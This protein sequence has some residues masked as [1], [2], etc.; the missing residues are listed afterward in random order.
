MIRKKVVKKRGSKTHGYGSKKK[1][2]GA[3]SRGGRGMAGVAK[4]MKVWLKK[5]DPGHLGKRGFKTLA[6]RKIISGTGRA[7]NLRDVEKLAN[8]NREIDLEKIG[9]GKVLATG[10]LK[11]PLT[12]KALAFSS[13]ARQK[14]EK[15]GGRAISNE[16]K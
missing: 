3:G 1:H 11:K 16:E 12:V 2:R 5:N 6:Q 15:T 7:I 14:I 10:S 13:A 9:Y 4:H 8:G